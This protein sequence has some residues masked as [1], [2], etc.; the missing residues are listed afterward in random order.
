MKNQK[1]IPFIFALALLLSGCSKEPI[2]DAK[3]SD[4]PSK[5]EE[6]PDVNSVSIDHPE[7]FALVP[8]EMRRT[9]SELSVNGV[10]APDVN[11]NVPVNVLTAGRVTDLRVR[12]GD[13]VKKGQLL[14]TMTSPDMSSA[15]SDYQKFQ[16]DA[17]LVKTQLERSQLLYSKGAIAQKDVQVAED[18]DQK[19]RVD[20]ATSAERIRILGGDVNHLSP[21]I[22]V[23]APVSGTIIEQNVVAASGI[24]SLDNAPNLLTIADLSH[25]WVLCDVYE[26]NLAQVHLGDRASIVLNAYPDRKLEGRVSNIASLLDPATRTA[27]V[28]V[29]LPN[30][31]RLMRPNMFATVVFVAQGT[32]SRITVPVSAILRLQDRDWVFVQQGAKRFRRTEVQAVPA[33]AGYQEILAGVQPGAM[34]AANALQFSRAIDN[35]QEQAH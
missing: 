19:A 3:A 1:H 17:R 21:L 7:L 28:R 12:L 10:V 9:Q 20:V 27:K 29:D 30:P 23:H 6:A 15:I 11:R 32:K 35:Q 18:A 22:E 13:D 25:V 34:V 4:P 26:N 2:V 31:N 16:A 24:K 14:L 33:T 5:V 8:V